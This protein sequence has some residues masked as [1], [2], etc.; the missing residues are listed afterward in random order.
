MIN[1]IHG[2]PTTLVVVVG[3]VELR[4][5]F[6]LI[7]IPLDPL[8]NFTT[9]PIS[10]PLLT[11]S[12]L[13]ITTIST[14]VVVIPTSND[15]ITLNVTSCFQV[16]TTAISNTISEIVLIRGQRCSIL[17]LPIGIFCGAECGCEYTCG[18]LLLTRIDRQICRLYSPKWLP[19]SMPLNLF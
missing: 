6:L 15:W 18:S 12:M 1:T 5:K 3:S 9:D 16:S 2:V 11:T 13:G 8:P 19:N 17:W 4:F 10:I 14:L 7:E